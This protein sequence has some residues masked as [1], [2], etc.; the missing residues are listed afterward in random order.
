[1][2]E[3]RKEDAMFLN[4]LS[5]CNTDVQKMGFRLPGMFLGIS[6]DAN[7]ATAFIVRKTAEEQ[8]FM[9]ERSRFDEIIN[10][11]L[12]RDLIGCDSKLAYKS[13]G[14]TLQSVENLPAIIA[15]LVQTGAVT[16]NGLI[17]F[18][19]DQF[20]LGLALY[21][22]EDE[23]WASMPIGKNAAQA[24][25]EFP[26]FPEFSEPREFPEDET[27]KKAVEKNRKIYSA[28]Q[29]IDKTAREFVARGGGC[30]LPQ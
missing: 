19:N 27:V 18:V 16:V 13:N 20:G 12:V 6:D 7:F 22:G 5:Y 21:D 11:T 14:P 4:Y 23:E 29:E 30:G 8:I 1:M 15:L 24:P 10:K 2:T 17:S 3:Y 28:L 26:E 25:R 9:P